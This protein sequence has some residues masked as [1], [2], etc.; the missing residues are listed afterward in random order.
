MIGRMCEFATHSMLVN[1]LERVRQRLVEQGLD[2]AINRAK[3]I[4]TRRRALEWRSGS[5]TRLGGTDNHMSWTPTTSPYVNGPFY[6]C[7][8]GKGGW[9]VGGAIV[10][11]AENCDMNNAQGHT[12][13]ELKTDLSTGFMSQ[14]LS[15]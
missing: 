12:N 6:Q 8:G 2:A 1:A 14:L 4:R 15:N 5:A 10:K 7:N 13:Y 11:L 9:S 3:A